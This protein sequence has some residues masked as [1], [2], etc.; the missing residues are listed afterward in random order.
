MGKGGTKNQ[1]PLF[2]MAGNQCRFKG[3]VCVGGGGGV[4][5]RVGSIGDLVWVRIF[6]SKP[7]VINIFPWY[8]KPLYGRYF[9]ARF[10]FPWNQ[11][12]GYFFLKSPIPP[13][14]VKWSALYNSPFRCFS[15]VSDMDHS[16][17][18]YRY[19]WKEGLKINKR[20]MFESD[21]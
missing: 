11:S 6:F 1:K 4:R 17:K 10:F 13:W 8:T 12:A 18:V 16:A 7:L 2:K 9:L 20:A 14:K 19:C 3:C 15:N 5:V 21:M